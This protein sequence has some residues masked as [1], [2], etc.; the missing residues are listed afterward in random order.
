[1]KLSSLG[2]ALCLL[3]SSLSAQEPK[4]FQNFLR[5][6]KQIWTAPLQINKKQMPWLLLIGAGSAA[7]I[8][9]DRHIA[10]A[11]PN[12]PGQLRWGGR[13]S[14]LG[15]APGVL[16][17]GASLLAIGALS[18]DARMRRTAFASWEAIGHSLILTYGIKVLTARDRPSTG[19]G[20]G[21]FWSGYDGAFRGN[22]SFPSGHSMQSWAIASVL[23][24][25]YKEKKWVPWLAYGLASTV[26]ASRVA[27]RRHFVS[28]VAVGAL[29]GYWIGRLVQDKYK[30]PPARGQR[31]G[32]VPRIQPLL[33]PGSRTAALSL[34]WAH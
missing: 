33:Q 18:D 32:L 5:T 28:D 21:H 16:G 12:S 13:I 27:A 24:H 26:S 6:E 11:L 8:A 7:L 17:A 19:S 30:L 22:R 20:D 29:A 10:H 3:T 23:A 4:P 15:S 14:W 9:S 34:T 2:L 1:M 31:N 25:E